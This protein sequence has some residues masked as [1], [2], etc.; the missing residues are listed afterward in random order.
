[1][2]IEVPR[3]DDPALD[4]VDD[5]LDALDRAERQVVELK[6]AVVAATV[7]LAGVKDRNQRLRIVRYLYWMERRINSSALTAALLYDWHSGSDPH[8]DTDDLQRYSR[9]HHKMREMVGP[10]GYRT[11]ITPDCDAWVPVTSRT[12][13]EKGTGQR[14]CE[15]CAAC[16]RRPVPCRDWRAGLKI[17]DAKR[18]KQMQAY[19]ERVASE[20][21]ELVALKER[22]HLDEDHLVRLYELMSRYDDR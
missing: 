7:A 18:E 8:I 2:T 12:A 10:I 15:E 9:W 20:Q 22:T 14:Y 6:K 3:P 19:R 5:A 21:A 16:P 17:D 11:C 1:M 4:A 13:L